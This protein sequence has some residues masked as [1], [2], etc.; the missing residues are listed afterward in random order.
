MTLYGAVAHPGVITSGEYTCA[1]PICRQVKS[2]TALFE[3]VQA[4]AAHNLWTICDCVRR[5]RTLIESSALE[6][7]IDKLLVVH[8]KWF[9]ESRLTGAWRD[10]HE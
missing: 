1:C 5:M 9:P 8:E 6:A 4:L 2:A 3:D 10:L 7:W